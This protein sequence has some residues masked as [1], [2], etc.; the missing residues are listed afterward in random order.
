[1]IIN[2]IIKCTSTYFREDLAE[3]GSKS[4]LVQVSSYA[5]VGRIHVELVYTLGNETLYIFAV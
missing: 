2:T 4:A 3:F 5:V 1:M